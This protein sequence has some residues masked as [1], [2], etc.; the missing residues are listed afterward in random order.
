MYM[1]PVTLA[2]LIGEHNQDTELMIAG[3][4]VKIIPVIL[5]FLS[6]QKYYIKGIM[7]GGIKG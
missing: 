4:F 6:L 7:L 2:H 1:L 5:V 3:S